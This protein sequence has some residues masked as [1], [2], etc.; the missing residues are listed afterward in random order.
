VLERTDV[1]HDYTFVCYAA[2]DAVIRLRD[3]QLSAAPST[4]RAESNRSETV[5]DVEEVADVTPGSRNFR[6]AYRGEHRCEIELRYMESWSRQLVTD[7]LE[8]SLCR[9]ARNYCVEQR[10]P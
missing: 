8:D 4:R 7:L 10:L 2:L 1:C 6:C 3:S 5:D 9:G